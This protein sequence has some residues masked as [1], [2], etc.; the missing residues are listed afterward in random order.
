[1]AQESDILTRIKSSVLLR[2]I[3]LM[4]K[5]HNIL[6]FVWKYESALKR[7]LGKW[8]EIFITK[9][10]EENYRR[11]FPETFQENDLYEIQSPSLFSPKRLFI[12]DGF[13]KKSPPKKP[14]ESEYKDHDTSLEET[15]K[16]IVT[17]LGN[18]DP[19]VILIF[20]QTGEVLSESSLWK[21]LEKV[22]IIKQY[23]VPELQQQET[24]LQ[25]RL[26]QADKNAIRL[27]LSAYS[28]DLV[29]LEKEV[30]KLSFFKETGTIRE[31]DI[32]ALVS[33]KS[34]LSIFKLIDAILENRVAFALEM[35][36]IL[37]KNGSIY[38][39][40][41]SIL[42]NL[43]NILYA[44]TLLLL[45][46]KP[47]EIASLLAIKPFTIEKASKSLAHHKKLF[48]LFQRLVSK[49]CDILMGKRVFEDEEARLFALETSI[50]ACLGR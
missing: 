28:D 47:S 44:Q 10:G 2:C 35:V 6:C 23:S 9:Y 13:L 21:S 20:A 14:G 11:I 7:D 40:Y 22:A 17:A 41:P 24:F 31:A 42:T 32:E 36:D 26:P 37:T 4:E 50:L 43:R 8:V 25:D 18:L 3:G 19:A 49:E 5:N 29:W 34:D 15:W 1:M 30:E 27:L 33:I 46:K 38:Q 45:W 12:F 16:K 48:S 39:I